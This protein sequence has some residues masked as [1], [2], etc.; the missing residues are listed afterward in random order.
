MS[1][2]DEKT[3]FKENLIYWKSSYRRVE[4]SFDKPVGKAPTKGQNLFAHCPKIKKF[5]YNFLFQKNSTKGSYGQEECSFDNSAES[6]DKKTKNFG[7]MS[8]KV[9]TISK[10]NLSP[11]KNLLDT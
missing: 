8:E 7:S 5:I 4:C 2:I 1:A 6:F 3:L 9:E 10:S 11:Q